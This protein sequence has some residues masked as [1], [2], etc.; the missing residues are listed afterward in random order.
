VILVALL[1]ESTLPPRDRDRILADV[2]RTG[3]PAR[4]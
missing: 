1:R 2:A 3:F 4:R